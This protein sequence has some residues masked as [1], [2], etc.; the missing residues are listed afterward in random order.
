MSQQTTSKGVRAA[1]QT[2]KSAYTNGD[3]G[4]LY[5]AYLHAGD[6]A[7]LF[8]A[9]LPLL[10]RVYP[11]RKLLQFASRLESCLAEHGLH[12]GCRAF[13]SE[14]SIPWEF[15]I[16]DRARTI[17][18]RAPAVFFGNHPSLF[19]PFL[20]AATV[21][22]E[23]FRFFSSKYVCHLLPSVGENSFPMEVPMTRS[24]TEW[25]RGGW[26]RALV[27][28]LISLL[29]AMPSADEVRASNRESLAQG[30]EFVRGG[31]S[32]IIC[33]GGGGKL[34][35]R[36]WFTG[37]GSL[38]KQLQ[39]HPGDEP[40]YL[41]PFREENSSNKRIYAHVQNGPVSRF[42][43]AVVYRGPLRIRFGEP[44]PVTE[45]GTPEST[46]HQLVELLKSYYEG[47]FPDPIP[48]PS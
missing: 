15:H 18:E 6:H 37:I 28:R 10:E 47:L 20:T 44:I 45:F 36:K 2:L 34:K 5:E 3:A 13:F 25:R 46:V 43:R 9:A 29:H 30:A 23:D 38:V 48:V 40:I 4:T 27:Y 41:I 33:P 11:V 1:I 19:T 17:A 42:K 26:Q 31:G 7:R 14:A 35:D 21:A 39:T 8:R 22:R 32:T 16:S 24:L 12:Q